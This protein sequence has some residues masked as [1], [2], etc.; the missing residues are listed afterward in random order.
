MLWG[1]LLLVTGIITALLIFPNLN[2][3]GKWLAVA[4]AAYRESTRQ[5]LFWLLLA[6]TSF[7]MLISVYLP[8]FTF[9]E[10]LKMMKGLSLSAILLATL[11]LTVFSAGVSIS[12]EI[13][14]RTAVTVLSKPMSR[15]AFLLGKF[16]GIFMSALLLAVLLSLVMAMAVYY[17][18]EIDAEETKPQL[19]EIQ[20]LER[21]LGFLPNAFL[22]AGRYLLYLSHDLS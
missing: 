6:L 10:E 22:A 17:R 14:G 2:L 18:N 5:P 4:Q 21:Y 9:G 3:R 8:Y 20:Q 16:F 1:V 12:E 7:F 11:I 19:A 15:R 13:E